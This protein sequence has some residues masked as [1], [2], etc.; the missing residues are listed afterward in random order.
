MKLQELQDRWKNVGIVDKVQ[1][2]NR[3]VLFTRQFKY[4]LSLARVI[5]LGALKRDE[6]R[7]SHFKPEFPN[8][9]DDKFLKT[10]MAKFVGLTEAPEIS[11][12]DVDISLMKPV[13]RKYD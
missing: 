11:Y 9:D 6:S 2:M 10:T 12:Q 7:G 5:A 13:A 8:R 4:M 3:E 1:R